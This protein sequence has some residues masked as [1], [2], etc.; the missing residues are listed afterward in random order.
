MVVYFILR[1][2]VLWFTTTHPKA[3]HYYDDYLVN[4]DGFIKWQNEESNQKRK[5]QKAQIKKS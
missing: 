2:G 1:S 3:F 5:P 4:N